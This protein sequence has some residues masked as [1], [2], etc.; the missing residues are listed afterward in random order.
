MATGR[1]AAYKTPA[2]VIPNNSVFF[3]GGGGE[4]QLNSSSSSS[5]RCNYSTMGTETCHKTHI[6]GS[7]WKRDDPGLI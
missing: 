1:H 6:L 5:R 7:H 4:G 3:G 2:A